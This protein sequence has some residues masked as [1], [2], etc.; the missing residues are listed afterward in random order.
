MKAPGCGDIEGRVGVMNPMQPPKE[1]VFVQ[2]AMLGVN[3][4]IQDKDSDND[5]DKGGDRRQV[6]KPN[7]L[8]LRPGR[9]GDGADHGQGPADADAN[10][11][12]QQVQPPAIVSTAGSPTPARLACFKDEE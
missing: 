2:G 12:K 7:P 11:P 10:D 9:G 4:K 1:R 3:R 8:A 5:S 6:Q